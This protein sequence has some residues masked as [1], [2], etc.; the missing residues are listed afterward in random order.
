MIIRQVG[1]EVNV[2]VDVSERYALIWKLVD[3][4]VKIGEFS[5]TPHA[6]ISQLYGCGL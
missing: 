1:A 5:F 3:E 2:D 6:A 4:H